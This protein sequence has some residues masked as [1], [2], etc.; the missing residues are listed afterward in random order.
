MKIRTVSV[1]LLLTELAGSAGFGAPVSTHFDSTGQAVISSS[2]TVEPSP[3]LMLLGGL[4]L[5]WMLMRF[6]RHRTY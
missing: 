6:R 3:W 2:S 4:G 1:L 5:L